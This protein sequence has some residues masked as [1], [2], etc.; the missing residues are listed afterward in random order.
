MAKKQLVLYHDKRTGAALM[1]ASDQEESVYFPY[2]IDTGQYSYGMH[3]PCLG[4]NKLPIKYFERLN[5]QT[6]R[7]DLGV[8]GDIEVVPVR[9]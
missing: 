9:S 3:G 7:G 5:P 4:A 2:N 8:A 6:K 1:I